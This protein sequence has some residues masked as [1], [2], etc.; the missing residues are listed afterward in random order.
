VGGGR[1]QPY[2]STSCCRAVKDMVLGSMRVAGGAAWSHRKAAHGVRY[3]EGGWKYER[4]STVISE[5]VA[6][7]MKV[8]VSQAM[9]QQA[10]L[11]RTMQ[12]ASKP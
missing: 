7:Y 6:T 9:L 12:R 4:V 11:N 5:T 8:G 3:Q 2:C 1:V 10:H